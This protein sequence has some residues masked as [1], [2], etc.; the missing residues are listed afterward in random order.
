MSLRSQL[1][2]L[3]AGLTLVLGLLGLLNP[4]LTLGLIGFEVVEPRGLG[5]ARALFGAFFLTMGGFMLWALSTRPRA[6]AV[7][8]FA[9]ILWLASALGRLLSVLL[10]G[11]LSLGSVLL[12]GFDLV[13]GAGAFLGSTE[14]GGNTDDRASKVAEGE[15]PLK[16][17]RP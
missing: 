11:T 4:I 2:Y 17:Y 14:A 12:F 1:A 3:A 6:R 16:A 15:D 7:L 5:E 9:A 10:D 13:V 8:R